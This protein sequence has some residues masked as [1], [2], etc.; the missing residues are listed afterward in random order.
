MTTGVNST[1]GCRHSSGATGLASSQ[2][3]YQLDHKADSTGSA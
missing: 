1:T 2:R 3:G